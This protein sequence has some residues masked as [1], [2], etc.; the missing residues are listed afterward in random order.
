MSP[1]TFFPQRSFT[2]LDARVVPVAKLVDHR[3][4]RPILECAC[5]VPRESFDADQAT[6]GGKLRVVHDVFLLWV[7]I[8]QCHHQFA[9]PRR[10]NLLER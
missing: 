2:L 1:L 5:R 3:D 8:G 4:V 10:V 7:D 6:L 9:F